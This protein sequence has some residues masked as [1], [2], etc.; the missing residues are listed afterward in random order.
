MKLGWREYK[1]LYE[2]VGSTVGRVVQL[3]NGVKSRENFFRVT[4]QGYSGAVIAAGATSCPFSRAFQQLHGSPS[5][6]QR[7]EGRSLVLMLLCLCPPPSLSS[8][9]CRYI[10]PHLCRVA[11]SSCLSLELSPTSSCLLSS[12]ADIP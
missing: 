7:G 4:S 3:R 9:P 6:E 5:S 1:A 11:P 8:F 10:G 12:L 2:M